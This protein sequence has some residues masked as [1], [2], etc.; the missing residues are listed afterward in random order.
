MNVVST[1]S[2]GDERTPAH[3]PCAPAETAFSIDQEILGASILIVDDRKL[4]RD[5]I[6]AILTKRG[7]RNLSFAVDGVLA[8]EALG[9]GVG[10]LFQDI[11]AEFS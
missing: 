4:M 9:T 6:G 2:P 8:L 5:M 3:Q 1:H 10:D 7:F 11:I